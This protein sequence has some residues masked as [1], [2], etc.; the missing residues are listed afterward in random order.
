MREFALRT[1]LE[2]LGGNHR[3]QTLGA[4]LDPILGEDS[5]RIK[6]AQGIFDGEPPEWWSPEDQSEMAA[7]S[8]SRY[9][10]SSMAEEVA[11]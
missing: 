11:D 1:K 9:A 7:M 4:R 10:S 3:L 8:A 2:R 5:V 6:A